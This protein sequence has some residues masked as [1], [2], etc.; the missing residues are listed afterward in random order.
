MGY[1]TVE[2]KERS[3]DMLTAQQQKDLEHYRESDPSVTEEEFL[4]WG[5]RYGPLYSWDI[6][7]PERVARK[8]RSNR[9]RLHRKNEL[10]EYDVKSGNP[11]GWR[12]YFEGSSKFRRRD[13]KPLTEYDVEAVRLN[14]KGQ[15]NQVKVSEDGMVAAH[16]WF[17][18]SSD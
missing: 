6:T 1:N 13:G 15:G 9:A 12:C 11:Y 7:N 5:E 8:I 4:S 14:V 18:D 16:S 10:E 17:C 2:S 3:L